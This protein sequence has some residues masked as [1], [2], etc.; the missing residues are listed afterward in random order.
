MKNN[1][2]FLALFSMLQL[3]LLS[4]LRAQSKIEDTDGD[5]KV[6]TE[7]FA[8][9]NVIRMDLAGMERF[10]FGQNA[11]G[12]PLLELFSPW[13]NTFIG[14]ST[15][16]FNIGTNNTGLGEQALAAN[17]SGN[18][19]TAV[20]NLALGLNTK[21]HS[22]TANGE[23]ALKNNSGSF[24]TA[25][26]RQALVSNTLGNNNTAQ[27]MDALGSNTTGNSNTAIGAAALFS[28]IKHSNLVAIGDSALYKNG[29]GAVF[30]WEAANNT[31]VGSKVLFSNTIG[32]AN[33][34]LG[35]QSLYSNTNG[36]FNNALGY[37]SLFSNTT[38]YRNNAVGYTALTLN[39]TG[40]DNNAVGYNALASN[41]SGF[42]N[43]AL[44]SNALNSN[45]TGTQNTATGSFSLLN[46]TTG[47]GNSAVGN[48]ALS[49]NTIGKSN[50]AVGADALSG[51]RTGSQNVA[52]G[53]RS[54]F[55]QLFTNSGV[56]YSP[57]NVAVGYEALFSNNPTGTINNGNW[58]VAVGRVALRANITGAANVGIGGA[59]GDANTTGHFNTYLGHDADVNAGNR[60]NGTAL[61][62]QA[63]IT[64]SNQVRVGNGS[65]TS[66]GGQVG[67]TALSDARFKTGVKENVPGL[68]FIN[69]LRPVTYHLNVEGFN[70]HIG[71]ERKEGDMPIAPEATAMLHTGF[72]AQ[73]VEKAAQELGFDFDGV[74]KPKNEKDVY[75]LRYAEFT[76]PLVKAVQELDKENTAVRQENAEL[77]RQNA[78]IMQRLEAIEKLLTERSTTQSDI[79]HEPASLKQNIPNPFSQNTVI[80]IAVPDQTTRVSL[81]IT[82]ETG[83]I[84]KEINITDKGEVAVNL[85]AGTLSAGVYYYTLIV[86]G[87]KVDTKKMILTR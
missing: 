77:K 35:Y 32:S 59:A 13:G 20:G 83:S 84:V 18:N 61:G 24:N 78:D 43:V 12:D 38:G 79:L 67:W 68:A 56:E 51:N 42:N 63:T 87:Q 57:G 81:C 54:L 40:Y 75:G 58:N 29:L 34:G 71:I 30:S 53:N 2:L 31:A 9:E 82:N 15:A 86:D 60:S 41:T 21:G 39:T 19:N 50:T 70:R 8:N 27:G 73:E 14:R 6:Q 5:T 7:K 46:N 65:V 26:G 17:I 72:L 74:D 64:A 33:T 23:A 16:F 80:Q 49:L 45:T 48:G 66:I 55:N 37:K 1:Y 62:Y 76:V 47:V 69:K 25:V 22:N 52:V 28:N 36:Y 85:A 10:V 44:G 11:S 4:P 3:H